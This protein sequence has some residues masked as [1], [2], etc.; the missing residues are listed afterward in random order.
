MRRPAHQNSES[1]DRPTA[2]TD[3]VFGK[4]RL[5]VEHDGRRATRRLPSAAGAALEEAGGGR[6]GSSAT[7]ATV[8]VEAAD[9]SDS[10]L[11]W[12]PARARSEVNGLVTAFLVRL[13]P[14]AL[15]GPGLASE[16]T[17]RTFASEP[18]DV[19]DAVLHAFILEKG[20]R[21]TVRVAQVSRSYQ[22]EGFDLGD[23]RL[24]A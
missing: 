17:V 16:S 9:E 3:S 1:A 8:T 14:E 15:R 6:G 13:K 19:S 11:G 4:A 12:R 23:R 24:N 18:G 21:P 2:S 10:S 22:L 7:G 20:T 5:G